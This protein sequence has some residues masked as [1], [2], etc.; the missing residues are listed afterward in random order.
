MD[1][2]SLEKNH[3]NQFRCKVGKY[4]VAY[5][6]Y[7]EGMPINWLP[8]PV[9]G[10]ALTDQEKIEVAKYIRAEMANRNATKSAELDEL[11]KLSAPGY[12]EETYAANQGSDSI[13]IVETEDA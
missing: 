9:S 13:S 4:V 1:A 12:K 6:C 8:K 7:G 3:P 11:T 5:V 2:L 10:L